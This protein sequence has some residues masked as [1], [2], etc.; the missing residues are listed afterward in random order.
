MKRRVF[1]LM[2]AVFVAATVTVSAPAGAGRTWTVLAGPWGPKDYSVV[3]QDFYPRTVEI[4]VGDTVTWRIE[5][6]HGVTFLS[7]AAPAEP[8]VRE[9]NDTYLNPKNEFPSGGTTYDGTGYRNSGS[10]PEFPK[11][12]I[13]SLTFTKTGTF[14]YVCLI[15][16]PAMSGTVIV[17]KK[18]TGSPAAALRRGRSELAASL[19]AGR[20]A[21]AKF[22]PE[23][24]AGTVVIP[25][26]GNGQAGFSILRFTP[27]PLVIKAGTT[28]TWTMR[29]PHEI[30]TVTFLG[31]EKPPQFIIPQPQQQGPPKLLINPKVLTPTQ[32]KTYDGMG[33]VNSGILFPA[34]SPPDLPK[35]FSLTFTKPGRYAYVC[36]VHIPVEG[37]VGTIIVK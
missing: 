25:L 35:S 19:K 30:H 28:V 13:Y 23:T 3:S 12:L 32:V 15:H 11:P 26:I 22:R 2:L 14:H 34:G 16:G 24:K 20:A 36:V 10:P 6:F 8:F 17:K 33:F 29:D 5:G 1:V 21:W 9:G 7:G 37:M 27:A 18:V 4:A 31:G